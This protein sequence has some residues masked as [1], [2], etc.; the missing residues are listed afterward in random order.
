MAFIYGAA[1]TGK[2]TMLNHISNFFAQK[3]KLYVAHT[4]PAV[5]NMRRRVIVDKSEFKTISKIV[6]DSRNREDCDILFIDE[7][8]TVSNADMRKLL[9]QVSFKLLVLVG[10]VYQIESIRFG[11]WFE[12]AKAFIPGSAISELVTPFRSTDA[13]LLQVW[14]RVRTLD[15]SILEALVKFGFSSRIDT[16]ILEPHNR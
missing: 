6:C 12:I 8:S 15:N 14:N 16:S 10:D 13:N 4:N 1:G 5:D 2:S 3:R 7:C 11:N 9:E